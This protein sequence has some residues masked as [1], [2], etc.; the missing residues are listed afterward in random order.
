MMQRSPIDFY[1]AECIGADPDEM[2][3]E[4]LEE[5]QLAEIRRLLSYLGRSRFYRERLA[6]IDPEEIRTAEDFR[7]LPVTSEKDLAGHENDFLCMNPGDVA[8][9]VT[10]PTTGTTGGSKRLAFSM[11]DLAKSLDFIR[12]AY[13]TFM[14]EGDRMMVMM[15]GGTPG[16][17][18]DVVKNSMAKMG[19]ETYIYGPISDLED[20]YGA[21]RDWKPDVITGIPVQIAALA[22]YSEIHGPISVREV[23]LSADDVP[24]SICRRL[25][26]A[27]GARTF[28][29]YG[30]TELCIAGGCEC[31]ADMGYHIRSCDHYFEVL[32]PDEEGYGEIAVTTFRHEA[33][34]LLRYRTGDFGRIDRSVCGCGSRLPRLIGPRGRLSNSLVFGQKRLFIRDIEEVVFSD[35]AVVDFECELEAGESEVKALITLRHL[36][37][38]LPD[39]QAVKRRIEDLIPVENTEIYITEEETAGFGKVYN[40]K[41]KLRVRRSR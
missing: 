38:D 36:A 5:W 27:W 26:D 6:G 18:G 34:P 22:R 19:V 31:C 3:A 28:R 33:M 25:K 23:L 8:R 15:S 13:T 39:I 41:K 2:S 4:R 9:M 29:H 32:D 14:H 21:V 35:P 17:I 40:S 24:D 10:V 7:K 20:A 30:M 11:N 16:S 12:V 37:G 1:I